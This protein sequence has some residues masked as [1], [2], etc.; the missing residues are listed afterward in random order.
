MR[1]PGGGAGLHGALS[2]IG[3]RKKAQEKKRL[4]AGIA[5]HV[6]FTGGNQESVA[7]PE[8]VLAAIGKRRPSARQNI[9]AFFMVGMLMR[10]AWRFTRLGYWDLGKT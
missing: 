6:F 8:R 5:G 7:G 10:A 3:N 9:N 2:D 1:S 4:V